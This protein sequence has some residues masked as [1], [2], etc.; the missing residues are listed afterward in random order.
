MPGVCAAQPEAQMLARGQASHLSGDEPQQSRVGPD[1]F[2]NRQLV[3]HGR[4]RLQV[5]RVHQGAGGADQG[6]RSE[7]SFILGRSFKRTGYLTFSHR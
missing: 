2:E 5:L 1:L 7:E 4:V 3:G 6:N